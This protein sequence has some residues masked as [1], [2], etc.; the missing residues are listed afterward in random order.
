MDAPRLFLG[1]DIGKTGHF[2][3]ALDAGGQ[4][5]LQ[6][7]VTND[8]PALKDLVCWA[9]ERQAA[10]VVDQP[11][12]T[13]ALLLHLCWQEGV[14]IGYLHGLAMARARDFYAGEAKTD[15]KDAFVLADVARAHPQRIV[16]LTPTSEARAR[17]EL[18]CGYDADL[19][20]DANRL[21][22]RLRSLLSTYWPALEQAYGQLA[23]PGLLA[24]LQKYPGPATLTKA[25]SARLAKLLNAHGVRKAATV[26]ERLLA[27]AGT[28]TTIVAGA[29]TATGL[30]VELAR[31]LERVLAR[32]EELEEEIERSFFGLP[33]AAILRSLPGIGPR[34]GA[35]I[36]VEIGDISHFSSPA[37]LAAYAGLGPTPRQS[38]TSIR[39]SVASRCGNHR[40]KNA[41]FLAAF[42]SLRHPASR[43]YYDRKRAQ[44]KKHNQAVLC[45]ARRRVDVLHA[46]LTRREMYRDS[47]PRASAQ[48]AAA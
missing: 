47:R 36:A 29:G 5:V 30:I 21:T 45:L 20:G 2:A 3:V 12:G 25:G 11:G 48:G 37:Q 31:E 19:R 7:A 44:G 15:P 16:W 40:L 32:R 17:L 46:M 22:N 4:T 34:L 35:R 41:L 9:L 38:G 1:V 24:L 18:L 10:L 23:T 33:E 39:G 28:Q 42:A 26:A 43:T 13:A 8:E 6:R 14:A 27:A